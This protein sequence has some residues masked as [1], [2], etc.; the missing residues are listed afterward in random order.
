[1]VLLFRLFELYQ[2]EQDP[3]H[4]AVLHGEDEAGQGAD[5]PLPDRAGQ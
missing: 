1:M 4:R 2:P 5:Q 3:E